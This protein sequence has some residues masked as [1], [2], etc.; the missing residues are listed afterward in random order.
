MNGV[1]FYNNV[2]NK[3]DNRK[4]SETH[5]SNISKENTNFNVYLIPE[6]VDFNIINK[7]LLYTLAVTIIIN[8]CET[9]TRKRKT[10]NIHTHFLNLEKKYFFFL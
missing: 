10:V 2:E 7:R 4:I 3:C 6:A 9:L 1:G 5:T 8:V